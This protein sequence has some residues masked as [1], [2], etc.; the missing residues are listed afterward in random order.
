MILLS[1]WE[2]GG[3]KGD[4][5]ID[6]HAEWITCTDVS[7]AM[8]REKSEEQ[9]K[10]DDEGVDFTGLSDV[11]EVSVSKTCDCATPDLMKFAASGK[12]VTTV[13]KIHFLISGLDT[14]GDDLFL[15]VVLAD[16]VIASWELNASGEDARPSETLHIRYEKISVKYWNAD[17]KAFGPR[18]WWPDENTEWSD[19]PHE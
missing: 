3:I 6:N 1:L 15:E 5:Q 10:K 9:G 18:G 2:N 13:A 8:T 11:G 12:H 17:D 19:A 16:P 4:S 14:A 7:F